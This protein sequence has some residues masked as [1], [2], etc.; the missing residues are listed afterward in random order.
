VRSCR[1]LRPRHPATLARAKLDG[2][3]P[4]RQIR[5]EPGHDLALDGAAAETLDISQQRQFVDAHQ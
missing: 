1:V 4:D 2:L 3:R 5:F